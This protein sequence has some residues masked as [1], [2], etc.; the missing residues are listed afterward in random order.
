MGNR[1]PEHHYDIMIEKESEFC[2]PKFY[3]PC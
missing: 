2:I 3:W 1:Y